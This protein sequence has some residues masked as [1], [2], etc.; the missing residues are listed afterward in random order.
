LNL[1]R[2]SKEPLARTCLYCGYPF[3][4]QSTRCAECGYSVHRGLER[5]YRRFVSAACALIGCIVFAS[6]V[7]SVS[8]IV[9]HQLNA[10]RSSAAVGVLLLGAILVACAIAA[11]HF[12]SFDL[13]VRSLQ[14]ASILIALVVSMPWIVSSGGWAGWSSVNT[15]VWSSRSA[16]LLAGAV[17][18]YGEMV[19]LRVP[20]GLQWR[21]KEPHVIVAI[22]YAV[23]L[24]CL[25]G[26]L[27]SL[28]P[29][30]GLL[31]FIWLVTPIVC[32]RSVFLLRLIIRL[33]RVPS[34]RSSRRVQGLLP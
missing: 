19:S 9:Y 5:S 3:S 27:M 18:F 4:T 28:T 16:C 31:A 2:S 23:G 22:V 10:G 30:L 21:R 17:I 29:L 7:T 1:R 6:T 14:S 34:V 20:V 33:R 24:M 12:A 15:I 32:I 26:S 8:I 13:I 25:A 11:R